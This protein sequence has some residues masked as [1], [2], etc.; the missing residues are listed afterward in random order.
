MKLEKFLYIGAFIFMAS[1]GSKKKLVEESSS[2]EKNKITQNKTNKEAATETKAVANES[3]IR[4]GGSTNENLKDTNTVTSNDSKQVLETETPEETVAKTY[5]LSS[6]HTQDYIDTYAAIAVREMHAYKI[7][8]S[9]TLA[10]GVLESGSGRSPLAL[11][12]NNHFGIKC[13]KGWKG[14]SVRHDDDALAECF[15]KYE[16]PETSYEDH[17]K[18]LTSRKRYARLFRLPITDYIG[19]AYGLKQ[20][21]YATD[22]KYP[23]KLIAIINKYNLQQYDTMSLADVGLDTHDSYTYTSANSSMS[24]YNVVKGDTLYSIAKR[25]GT[26]VAKLKEVNGLSTNIISI[27]QELVIP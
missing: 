17:S 9:I 8:A 15:R 18:F 19:W 4:T 25:Y 24:F 3:G 6:N 2:K 5:T 26:T 12:S 20:A 22:K 11:K 1:C 16:K 23:N 13:H 14:R 21:G 10:Q 7:P 27:G